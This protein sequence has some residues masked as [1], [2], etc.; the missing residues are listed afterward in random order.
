[1][2]NS[3]SGME[4]SIHQPVDIQKRIGSKSRLHWRYKNMETRSM[5]QVMNWIPM[6]ECTA[7][8]TN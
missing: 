3:T 7:R 4:I 2:K 5:N 8:D 6:R 1:M